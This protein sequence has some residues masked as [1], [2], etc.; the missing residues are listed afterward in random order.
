MCVNYI[1]ELEKTNGGT[2]ISGLNCTPDF[3]I[4]EMQMNS[5]KWNVVEDDD[6]RT[7]YHGYQSFDVLEKDLTPE[8]AHQIGLELVKRLYPNFQVVVSTHTDRSHIH[9][10]FVLSSVNLEGRKLEDRLANPREGLYGLRDTSDQIALEH[11]LRIINDA[12]KIGKY[13]KKK[14]LYDLANESWRAKIITKIE[15]L[16]DSCFTYDELLE[17]L[18]LDGY[19]IKSGK[20]IKVK[21]YGKQ[22]YVSLKVLGEDYE[23]QNLKTFFYNK[24][25]NQ[26]KF[27][28]KP[29][30][31]KD[32]E[33][34]VMIIQSNKAKM[35]KQSI[36]LSM[37]GLKDSEVYLKYYNSRYKEFKRYNKLV[38]SINFLNEN[39]IYNYDD[40]ANT[41]KKVVLEIEEKEKQYNEQFSFNETMQ[42]RV[43][44]AELYIK[45]LDHYESYLEHLKIMQDN[46]KL[47]GKVLKIINTEDLQFTDQV[48]EELKKEGIE[49][50]SELLAFF[51]V[52]KELE[53]TNTDEVK[54]IIVSSNRIKEETNRQ[55]AYLTYLKNKVSELTKIRASSLEDPGHIKNFSFNEKMIDRRRTTEH[56]YCIKIPYSD[57]YIYLPSENI[58]WS[59][60]NV[61]GIMYLIDDKEY[62]LYDKNNVAVSKCNGEEIENISNESKEQVKQYYAK[63]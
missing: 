42:L 11:G 9:N 28:F 5:D 53:A 7:C 13:K 32:S 58:A 49:I 29:F 48:L 33:S 27:D 46:N 54:D 18:A 51:D 38:E 50:S 43:P 41:L 44:L 60:Y 24:C 10:H 55:Y 15:L 16:K 21:P 6:S 59:N 25:R 12:P 1:M 52:K 62:E 4:Q 8:E 35:S 39:N 34:E 36:L 61:R 40:L 56:E 23:E 2:L 30:V 63:D 17:N 14:Y 57:Y 20:N 3:A 47:S 37:K 45:L 22:K 19:S 26:N 31:I